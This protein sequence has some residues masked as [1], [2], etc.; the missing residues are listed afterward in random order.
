[1]RVPVSWL[2]EYVAFDGSVEDLAEL[3]S[4]S[5]SEVENIE[6]MGAPRDADNVARFVVGRVVTRQ[7]HPN[8]DK[9]SLCT[10]D[11]GE[12]SGGVRQIVCGADNFQAGDTV[13]V[14]L[15]GAV[16]QGG[17]KLRKAAIRGVE[18]DGM[19]L[20]EKELGYEDDSAGIVILPSDWT[21]GAP[22][23]LSRPISGVS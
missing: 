9:L 19:M 4:M 21:V 23:R 7:K 3:L 2:R 22:G 11:V 6:W 13:A 17:L 18:S 20:S 8:A 15:T 12:S 5:G 14:S 10:V 1:M 16:L